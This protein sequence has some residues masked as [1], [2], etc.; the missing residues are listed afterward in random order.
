MQ[1]GSEHICKQ[2]NRTYKT[3]KSLWNHNKK[4]HNDNVI[5]GDHKVDS[6]RDPKGDHLVITS[7]SGCKYCGIQFNNRHNRWRHEQKCESNNLNIK[8][9]VE[10]LKKQ[11]QNLQSEI[12]E[13]KLLLQKSLKIHPK[14]LQKINNQL[15]NSG[16]INSNN[17]IYNTQIIQLGRE[18]LTEVLTEKQKLKILN[19]QAMSIND[20]VELVHTSNKFN[21]FKN[22]YITNLQSS[23]C[24]RYDEKSNSFIAVNKNELL[25]DLIDA[26]M[27][28]I[29]TF[30]EELQH[31]MDPIK[32]EQVKRFIDRMEC[33]EDKIKGVKKDEIKLILYNHRD[34]IKLIQ[35]KT[36][37]L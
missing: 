21:Q 10:D 34:Q 9:D 33:D 6:T 27:Y 5:I 11:N 19:R 26:R 17:N 23:F 30:Y 22:V 36:L 37:E 2:C 4:F 3:Y 1:S 7:K 13:L 15:N 35:D 31:L 32:A 25:D 18:N 16:N 14:T 24:Y 20:L 8:S 29:N 12:N 28:D